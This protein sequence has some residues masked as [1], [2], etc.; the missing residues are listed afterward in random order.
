MREKL[1]GALRRK[2][3]RGEQNGAGDLGCASRRESAYQNPRTA[4]LTTY[5]GQKE[6]KSDLKEG[7]KSGKPIEKEGVE[8]TSLRA[9]KEENQGGGATSMNTSLSCSATIEGVMGASFPHQSEDEERS[10]REQRK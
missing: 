7:K 10:S 1:C 4:S 3:P 9:Q 6:E 5:G 8:R 2:E